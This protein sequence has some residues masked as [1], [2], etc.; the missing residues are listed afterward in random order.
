MLSIIP[1]GYCSMH[2]KHYA[3]YKVKQ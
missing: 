2:V 3:K 1:E